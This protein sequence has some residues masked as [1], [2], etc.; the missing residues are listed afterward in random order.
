MV[1]QFEVCSRLSQIEPFLKVGSQNY[2][3][4][5]HSL[6]WQRVVMVEGFI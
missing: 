3:D 2:T 4:I 1:T 5:I 6:N